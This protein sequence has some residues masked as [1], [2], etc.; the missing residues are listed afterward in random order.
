MIWDNCAPKKLHSH[1]TGAVL[2]SARFR[3]WMS[4]FDPQSGMVDLQCRSYEFPGSPGVTPVVPLIG[5]GPPP[6]L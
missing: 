4:L 2:E 5:P 3:S 1:T 6:T